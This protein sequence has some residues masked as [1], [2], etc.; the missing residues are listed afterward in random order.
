MSATVITGKSEPYGR[1]VAGFVDEGPC[2]TSA[3]SEKV[4]ADDVEA[5][6]VEG[7]TRTDHPIPPAEAAAA[8]SVAILGAKPVARALPDRRFR[9]S[10]R[11]G[12]AAQ[13]VTNQNDVVTGGGQCSVSLVSDANRMQQAPAIELHRIRKIEELRLDR[14]GR[15]RGIF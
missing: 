4:G 7:F 3:A 2:G 5:I 12:V 14:A 11:V 8:R 6:G 15:S 13:R 1:P 9:E 10:R